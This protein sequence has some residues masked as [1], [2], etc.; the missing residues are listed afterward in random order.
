LIEPQEAGGIAIVDAEFGINLVLPVLLHGQTLP[1]TEIPVA[2]GRRDPCVAM[3][4]GTLLADFRKACVVFL[5]D[6][7]FGNLQLGPSAIHPADCECVV[8]TIAHIDDVFLFRFAAMVVGRHLRLAASWGEGYFPYL[9][10][11]HPDGKL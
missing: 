7:C 1:S 11:N 4:T 3:E 5:P 10:Q 2:V 9:Y 6:F 8:W